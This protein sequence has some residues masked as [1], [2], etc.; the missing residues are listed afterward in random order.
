[1]K[2]IA[3]N[4]NEK[5]GNIVARTL[6]QC[7]PIVQ[8]MMPN[9]ENIKRSLRNQRP[10]PKD[11]DTLAQLVIPPEYTVTSGLNPMRFLIY[12]NGPLAVNRIIAFATDAGLRR[13]AEA[14]TLF[15]DGNF[16]MSP[17]LFAQV[18]FNTIVGF[19]TLL[20]HSFLCIFLFKNYIF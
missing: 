1:M 6:P 7:E 15:M 3:L 10:A 18:R 11:P 2:E 16:A 14:E 8:A 19:N 20:R 9:A 5:P 17:R 4:T 12:D 13:L